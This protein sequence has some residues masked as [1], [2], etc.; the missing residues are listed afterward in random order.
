[1]GGAGSA[2]GNVTAAAEFNI[3]ADAEAAR[4]VFRAGVP[5]TLVGIEL[6]RGAARSTAAEYARFAASADPVARFA[7]LMCGY[8]AESAV[9][10]YGWAGEAAIP[11]AV[12]M[13]IALDPALA[14]THVDCPVDVETRGDLTY[15]ETVLD[16]RPSAGAGHARV[17]LTLDV[18]GYKALLDRAILG[19]AVGNC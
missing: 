12:A 15:G 2:H 6:C 4:I 17:C 10:R 5:L 8:L 9:R 16:R 3:W 13:A 11:D 7:G 14:L 1:M 19:E 18:P